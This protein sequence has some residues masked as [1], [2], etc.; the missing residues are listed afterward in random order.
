MDSHKRTKISVLAFAD[1]VA[2]IADNKKDIKDLAETLIYDTKKVGL[3]ANE[4]KTNFM[5]ISRRPDNQPNFEI[6]NF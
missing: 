4:G 3:L 1:D 5:K 6:L 2:L